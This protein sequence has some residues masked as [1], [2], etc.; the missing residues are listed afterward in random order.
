MKL[1]TGFIGNQFKK[2][3]KEMCIR[4]KDL[5]KKVGISNTHLSSIENGLDCPS[6]YTFIKL[7]TELCVTPDYI[8]LGNMRLNG[9]TYDIYEML[10]LCREQ[11][12]P[13]IKDIIKIYVENAQRE[14]SHVN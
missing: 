9:I 3:R 11:D 13:I 4:Q 1:E 5:A 10:R 7:C 2:R 8:L 14:Q 12:L 6:L